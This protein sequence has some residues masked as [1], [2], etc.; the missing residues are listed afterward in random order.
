M[1]FLPNLSAGSDPMHYSTYNHV[2]RDQLGWRGSSAGCA[3]PRWVNLPHAKF[4]AAKVRSLNVELGRMSTGGPYKPAEE[5]P[6]HRWLYTGRFQS[7]ST[8]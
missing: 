7:V 4:Q 8:E 6:G 2:L 5:A 1:D 3:N